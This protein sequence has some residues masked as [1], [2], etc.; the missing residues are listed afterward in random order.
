MRQSNTEGRI[1]MRVFVVSALVAV[2]VLG[3]CC[4]RCQGQEVAKAEVAKPVVMTSTD[5]AQWKQD[6]F[7]GLN[8]IKQNPYNTVADLLLVNGFGLK[9]IPKGK[10]TVEVTADN[11]AKMDN[12]VKSLKAV[13]GFAIIQQAQVIAENREA[14][15]AAIASATDTITDER[16]RKAFLQ[17][18]ILLRGE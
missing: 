5:V 3:C 2:V 6:L 11:K 16:T 7:D 14:V 8:Q 12:V 1:M 10:D 13:L 4:R 18:A 15:D 9:T 17:K